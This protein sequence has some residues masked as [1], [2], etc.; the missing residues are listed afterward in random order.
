MDISQN[1]LKVVDESTQHVEIIL[2][3]ACRVAIKDSSID[4]VI[5]SQVIE[6]VG[7]DLEMANEIY[8][9]SSQELLPLSV[10]RPQIPKQ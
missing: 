5:T 4:L 7:D 2:G 8:Y 10:Q 1:R 6:H 3:D 9:H